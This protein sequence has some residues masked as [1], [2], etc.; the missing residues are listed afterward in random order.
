MY[1]KSFFLVVFSLLVMGVVAVGARFVAAIP[2]ATGL[3]SSYDPKLTVE[4][5]VQTSTKPLLIEFYTDTCKTCQLIT[6]WVY[7]LKDNYKSKVTFVMVDVDDPRQGSI[8]GIFGIE[9]VPTL[10]VF[11]FKNMTKVQV[12]IDGYR[13]MKSLDRAIAKA[14]QQS[15][16]QAARKAKVSTAETSAPSRF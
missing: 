6:P 10:Y 16:K 2:G 4:E 7:K 1:R 14:I 9:Y 12:S 5:A 11:D 3:P 13:S 8:A 15:E